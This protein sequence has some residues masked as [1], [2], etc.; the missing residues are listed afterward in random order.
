ML[1][2]S[3]KMYLIPQKQTNMLGG[4][5]ND[6]SDVRKSATHKLDEEMRHSTKYTS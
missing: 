4:S 6:G 1:E 3:L 5:S 2:H